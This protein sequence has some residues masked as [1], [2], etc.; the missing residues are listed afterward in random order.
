M[1]LE[2]LLVKA[3]STR[4]EYQ[5]QLC[6][7]LKLGDVDVLRSLDA[8]EANV[9]RDAWMDDVATWMPPKRHKE[10]MSM[11]RQAKKKKSA[12]EERMHCRVRSFKKALIRT[13]VPEAINQR[14]L[15]NGLCASSFPSHSWSY[16]DVFFMR[17]R[18]CKQQC[19]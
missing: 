17:C 18:K 11:V 2:R 5:K 7:H 14:S 10:Y 1:A 19:M 8:N 13:N 12:E 3:L 15:F 9:L 6:W 4:E 16:V